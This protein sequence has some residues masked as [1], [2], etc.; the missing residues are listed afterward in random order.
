M[1]RRQQHFDCAARTLLDFDPASDNE[2]AGLAVYMNERHH[3]EIAVVAMRG[4][5]AGNRAQ[6]NWGYDVRS[7]R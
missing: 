7:C 4:Q 1:G 3:Y 6:A 5:A 2:E